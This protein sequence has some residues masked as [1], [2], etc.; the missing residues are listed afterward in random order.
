MIRTLAGLVALLL[1]VWIP[2][3]Q[4]QGASGPIKVIIPLPPGGAIDVMVRA[5]GRAFEQRNSN[6][7]VIESR[8]GA[9][10]IIAANACKAAAPDGRTICLLSSST[11]S[12][13]PTLY[14]N[15]SYDPVKDFEPITNVAFAD[16]VLILN[17][18]VAV[19]DWKELVAYSK[20]NPKALN[21]G[22]FGLGGDTHLIVEWL[23]QQSGAQITHVPYKGA[24]DAMLAFTA[25]D[26]QLLYLIVG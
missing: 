8:P 12:I 2:P 25:N 3:A 17:T 18:K 1:G 26:I 5:I 16:Q 19:R 10:T 21:F 6:G 20:Q 15:L 7:L 4:A 11:V 9:N 13:N 23:K 24:A 22:S 14:R